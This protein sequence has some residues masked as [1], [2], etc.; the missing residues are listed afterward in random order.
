ML[1]NGSKERMSMC[2]FVF[3]KEDFKIRSL[4]YREFSYSEFKA[5]VQE[6]IKVTGDKVGL[7]RF[8]LSKR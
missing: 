4:S 1:A 7:K 8:R 2:F 5:Q 6:D 3:P